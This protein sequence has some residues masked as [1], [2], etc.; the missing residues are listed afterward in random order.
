[1]FGNL[2]DDDGCDGATSFVQSGDHTPLPPSPRNRSGL[3]GI[4]N[5]GSTCFLNSALQV[6]A[7]TP[8][9]RSELLIGI[10]S[11]SLSLSLALSVYILHCSLTES[12]SHKV[13]KFA[14]I[15]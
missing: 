14:A 11:L 1:M 13:E 7:L 3:A 5:Q 12:E 4:Y 10:I 6:L 15:K 8:E 2:F 9:F